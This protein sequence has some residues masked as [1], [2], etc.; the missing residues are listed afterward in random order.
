MSAG[1]NRIFT[2]TAKTAP[3]IRA[4]IHCRST[5]AGFIT[6][7]WAS[8][9]PVQHAD[10]AM[11]S[12]V[13]WQYAEVG[14]PGG[15]EPSNPNGEDS[16][17]HRADVP[18]PAAVDTLRGDLAE[19]RLLLDDA[20]PRSE[21]E[22]LQREINKLAERADESR[23]NGNAA[24]VFASI[25]RRLTEIRDAL[26]VLRPAESLLGMARVAQQASRK[27]EII[28]CAWDPA[29]LE[30]LGSAVAAMRSVAA[31]AASPKALAKLSEEVRALGAKLDDAQRRA[32]G[33]ILSML[34]GRVAMLVDQLQGRERSG[35]HVSVELKALIERLIDRIER[36]EL[37]SEHSGAP[38]CLDSLI[39]RLIEK[40]DACD[41]RLDQLATI[42]RALAELL[43]H[44]ERWHAPA[45]A[46]EAA[47]SP[48][49]EALARHVADLRQ[50]EKQIEDSLEVAHGTLAHVV[51]R[52]VMIESDLRGKPSQLPDTPLPVGTIVPSMALPTAPLA[53][54]VPAERATRPEQPT[55]D[56]EP[57]DTNVQPD[58]HPETGSGAV[59]DP[60]PDPSPD[61][62]LEPALARA[63]PPIVEDI[64]GTSTFI[65]AAR[66]AAQKE[67]RSGP[68]QSAPGPID[69]ASDDQPAR[70]IGRTGALIGGMIIVTAL[71]A[72]QGMG[73]LL[74]SSDEADVSVPHQSAVTSTND[75]LPA[76]V[77]GAAAG[78]VPAVEHARGF[79]VL[80]PARRQ[81][82]L[83]RYV[84]GAIIATPSPGPVMPGWTLEQLLEA[85]MSPER[86]DNA[87]SGLA[88]AVTAPAR[89]KLPVAGPMLDL[90][91]S[92]RTQ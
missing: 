31:Q 26:C 13:P 15:R 24:A 49:V 52:L 20:A 17:R 42:E 75:I 11:K 43:T 72:L 18:N 89:R 65:A 32:D 44:V 60:N 71:G 36:T 86:W 9:H 76:P 90:G 28:A 3:G 27:I 50:A 6:A 73:F 79:A 57:A 34:E 29:V 88:P 47:P 81:L 39:A 80:L 69:A 77:L 19:I 25:E 74:L 33:R 35:P 2:R 46:R 40:L 4:A 37:A 59:G 85:Q 48:A 64:S 91:P 82:D 58:R 45:L 21:I 56:R 16:C 83:F 63:R 38:A 68:A 51:D 23:G 70:R 62:S 30:Q 53:S 12:G 78:P 84:D 67:S 1:L 22:A 14:R 92:R 7:I 41:V 10:A 8:L 5:F 55:I 54:L 87:T 61:R 66:R